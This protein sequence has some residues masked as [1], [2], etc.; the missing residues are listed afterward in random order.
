M[1]SPHHAIW[2]MA[3]C[4]GLLAPAPALAGAWGQAPGEVF[5][6]LQGSWYSTDSFFDSEGSRRDRGGRFRK[7]ELNPYLEYGLSEAD[8]LTANLFSQW[9]E[10]D[11]GGRLRRNQGPAE[12][13]L[14][15]K[16]RLFQHNGGV[17]AIHGLMIVPGGSD[18]AKTPRLD[19]DRYG[20]EANLLY[21]R[22]TTLWGKK[23]LLDLRLGYR[24]Y[25]G[26]PASQIRANLTGGYDIAER[27]QVL[28]GAEL[29]HGLRNDDSEAALDSALIATDY[30]LLKL[31]LTLRYQLS[32]HASLV[33]GGY[34][35]AWGENTGGGGGGNV[36][37]WYSF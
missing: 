15:W 35:H 12:Q 30:R 23:A 37:L 25:F 31:S 1:Q 34:T 17:L 22:S 28:L 33:A 27:W 7:Y 13:E 18:T 6:S 11:A 19:T 20:A 2:S 21:G 8:S 3:L 5:F 10:D 9:L 24:D 36:G 32:D 16:R 4:F 29:H 26:Y 14:G